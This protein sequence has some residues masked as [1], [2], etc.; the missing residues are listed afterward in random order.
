MITQSPTHAAQA[1][2]GVDVLLPCPFCGSSEGIEIHEGS[3]F[4]WRIGYC[5]GCGASAGEIRHNTLATN[6]VEAEAESHIRVREAWNTRA[7]VRPQEK[8]P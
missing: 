8:Q 5:L 1:E 4:R 7:A 3:T 6:Q 2:K